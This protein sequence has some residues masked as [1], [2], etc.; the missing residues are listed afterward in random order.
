MIT[1][2]PE[3]TRIW[4]V[5]LA[6]CFVSGE[7]STSAFLREHVRDVTDLGGHAG[8]GHDELARAP[9]DVR[10]HVD[11]VGPVAQ[12]RVGHR[13][14]LDALGHGHAL[15]GQR[16]LGDLEGR[17]AQEAAVGGDDV[18][19]LDRHDVARDELLGRDLQELAAATDLRLDDHHLLQR[20]HRRRGLPLLV[21]AEHGVEKRQEEHV[22]A[23][24]VLVLRPDAAD[25]GDEQD[26][27][28][29][30]AVLAYECLPA[31][32]GLGRHE[33][34]RAVLLESLRGLVRWKS[35]VLVDVE[36]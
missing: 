32:L 12:R 22:E 31:R 18:A 24:A 6:S 28:H 1:A 27:L 25:P 30:V 21:Q 11:H 4:L 10:V 16:R 14:R 34:V 26:D 17:S 9:R 23:R 19:G 13:D 8:L 36:L 2:V 35:R 29:P 33:G 20:G 5:S 15:A 3:M 7:E